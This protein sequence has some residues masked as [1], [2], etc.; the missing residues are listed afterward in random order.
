M[1]MNIKKTL[2]IL[3]ILKIKDKIKDE[4]TEAKLLDILINNLK[5][6]KKEKIKNVII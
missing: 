5:Y 6:Q 3:M 1:I 4:L 2:L